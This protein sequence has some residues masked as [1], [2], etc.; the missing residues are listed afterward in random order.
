MAVA[1]A[2]AARCR[3]MNAA[4]GAAL[5]SSRSPR[6]RRPCSDSR[7][8]ASRRCRSSRCRCWS[9]SGRAPRRRASA[10]ATG[11]AFGLGLF[12][13][14]ASWVFIALNTFGGMPLPLAAIGH[15]RASARSSRSSRRGAGGSRPRDGR[16]RDRG[17][18]PSRPP[19]PGRWPNGR[20]ASCSRASRG[21]RSATRRWG[22]P[23]GARWPATRRSAAY[24]WS[25]SRSRGR[26]GGARAHRRR[27]RGRREDARCACCSA[28]SP[29]C[30]RA[31]PR[32]RA[33]N[34]RRPSGAP[35]AVSLVQG[36]V[37]QE[38][39]FDP[40]FRRTTFDLYLRLVE[41]EPRTA[42]RAARERVP[43]V[44][45]RGARGRAAAGARTPWQRATATR[46]SA[47]SPSS[48]RSSRAAGCGTTT[49]S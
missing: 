41:R 1:S 22:R 12:G 47:C 9:C 15:R 49:A 18:A 44:R 19:R 2:R 8:S 16:R 35:V 31:A 23:A 26:G 40:D 39:K 33:S 14:G 17:S 24:S 32:W 13:A 37:T 3:A 34:G 21:S 4:G 48:R 7:R 38:L 36:N 45:G 30:S 42:R 10:A 29:P 27:D 46:S 11:F 6:A 25:R 28:R 20:A 5:L 43:G